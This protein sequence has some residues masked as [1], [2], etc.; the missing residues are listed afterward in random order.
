MEVELN[1][2]LIIRIKLSHEDNYAYLKKGVRVSI[3]AV[4]TTNVFERKNKCA[5]L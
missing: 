5:C 1:F 4:I 3:N 2:L